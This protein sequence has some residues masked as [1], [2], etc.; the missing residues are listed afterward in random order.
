[1]THSFVILGAGN[2]IGQ[3]M[4]PHHNHPENWM[5]RFL[6]LTPD[7]PNQ[8]LQDEELRNHIWTLSGP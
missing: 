5:E 2:S 6:D 7:P 8:N 4:F 3:S 1:M